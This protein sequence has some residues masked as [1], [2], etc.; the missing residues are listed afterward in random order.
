M[1]YLEI[2]DG[3]KNNAEAKTYVPQTQIG[4]LLLPLLFN[5]GVYFLICLISSLS[6]EISSLLNWF[7]DISPLLLL[8]IIKGTGLDLAM[9]NFCKDGSK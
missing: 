4:I 9:I 2:T 6:K 7:V 8:L 3:N 5:L 1:L